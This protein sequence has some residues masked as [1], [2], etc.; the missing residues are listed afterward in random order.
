M[1]SGAAIDARW[2]GLGSPQLLDRALLHARHLARLGACSS[3]FIHLDRELDGVGGCLRAQVV[4]A[5]LQAQ[6][7]AVEVHGREFR[8]GGINHVDVQ[9]L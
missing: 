8:S 1:L 3:D 2:L 9:G 5:R 4:H 6:L 7:P